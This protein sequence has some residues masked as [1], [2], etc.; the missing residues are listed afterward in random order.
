M[1]KQ[2]KLTPAEKLRRDEIAGYDIEKLSKID[3][4]AAI[5][6]LHILR[7]DPACFAL[8]VKALEDNRQKALKNFKAR[9]AV[10]SA[11]PEVV[12]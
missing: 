11:N 6:F 7:H 1:G 5:A 9:E 10:N 3:L 4:D 12:Q 8:V 2:N